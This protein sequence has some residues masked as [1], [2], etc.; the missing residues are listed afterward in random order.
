MEMTPCRSCT[1]ETNCKTL[2]M[3]ETWISRGL[4]QTVQLGHGTLAARLA[5]IPDFDTAFATSV[6]MTCGVANGNGAHHLTVAQCVDLTG[7]AWD[8]RANEGVGWEGHR[9][10]LAICTD[11]KGVSSVGERRDT[12]QCLLPMLVL[13]NAIHLSKCLRFA[14]RN[15]CEAGWKARGSHVGVRIKPLTKKKTR[16]TCLNNR[17]VT[18]L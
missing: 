11:M 5:D 4:Y 1:K 9:L 14:A 18:D 17:S 3:S 8:T 2:F 15:G 6:D 16:Y 10:H 13:K 7:V 12:F